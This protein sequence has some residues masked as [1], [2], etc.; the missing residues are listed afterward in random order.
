[1]LGVKAIVDFAASLLGIVRGLNADERDR[2]QR[3]AKL[4]GQIADCMQRII[5]AARQKESMVGHCEELGAYFKKFSELD[6]G[7]VLRDEDKEL[8]RQLEEAISF[9][10]G[11]IFSWNFSDGESGTIEQNISGMERAIGSFRAA[12]NLLAATA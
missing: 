12:Q 5:D 3:V 6:L 9:R 4:L 8:L 11:M 10:R 7:P 2:L 1:M